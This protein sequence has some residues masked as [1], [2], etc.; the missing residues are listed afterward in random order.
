MK[1][2]IIIGLL[3]FAPACFSEQDLNSKTIMQIFA[4]GNNTAGFYTK[5]GLQQ[6]KYQ[7]MYLTLQTETGKAHFAMLLAAKAAGQKVVRMDYSIAESGQC[8]LNG[9]H[10]R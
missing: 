3:L 5:E 4:E 9:L 8:N 6:C 2:I 10:I 1:N 7:I